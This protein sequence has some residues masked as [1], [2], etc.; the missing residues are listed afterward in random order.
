MTKTLKDIVNQTLEDI[1]DTRNDD[2]LLTVWI[3]YKLHKERF[4]IIDGEKFVRVKDILEWPREESIK[5][6]RAYIQNEEHR[7]LPTNPDVIKKRRQREEEWRQ[8]ILCL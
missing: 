4:K 6:I 8:E 2:A 5:R 1:P 3:W 7:F